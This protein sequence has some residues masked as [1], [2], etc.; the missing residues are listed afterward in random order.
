[1]E[2]LRGMAGLRLL[3]CLYIERSEDLTSKGWPICNVAF[4]VWIK[5][6]G[7]LL[8]R[9]LSQSF[10][11]LQTSLFIQVF[12]CVVT[13]TSSVHNSRRHSTPA[14]THSLTIEKT[15]QTS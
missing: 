4:S 2:S 8:L 15:H 10:H 13:L 9:M 5:W 12:H 7:L 11:N 1:M 3:M 14:T 6:R